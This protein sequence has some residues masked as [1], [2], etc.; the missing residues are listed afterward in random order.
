MGLN[1]SL[2]GTKYE[3]Q[4]TNVPLPIR[5]HSKST[6]LKKINVQI[7][8]NKFLSSEATS[9]ALSHSELSSVLVASFT[10]DNELASS[11]N[12]NA[13]AKLQDMKTDIAQLISHLND[14]Y[15][16]DP[17]ATDFMGLLYSVLLLS[18]TPIEEK[19]DQIFEWMCLSGHEFISFDEFYVALVSLDQ[20]IA[21]AI[22]RPKSP[23][24]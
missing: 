6:V 19:I 1:S 2:D 11:K 7:L 8:W 24:E 3:F 5:L 17:V 20:G 12:E 23:E 15:D 9:F 16:P 10:E 22:G 14:L 18:P 21:H 4:G 13:N